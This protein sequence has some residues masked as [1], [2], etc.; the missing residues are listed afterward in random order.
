MYLADSLLGEWGCRVPVILVEW[1]LNT[2]DG[3]VLAE[4]LVQLQQLLPT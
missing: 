1:I 3:V 2:D 4:A